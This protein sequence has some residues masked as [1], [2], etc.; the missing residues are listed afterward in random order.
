MV[1]SFS[2]KRRLE[3]WICLMV[4]VF[5]NPLLQLLNQLSPGEQAIRRDLTEAEIRDHDK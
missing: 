5:T 2:G 3:D 4:Y 1:A